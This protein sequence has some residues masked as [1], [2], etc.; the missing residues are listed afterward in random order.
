MIPARA[1]AKISCR[2]VAA[3]RSQ[4]VMENLKKFFIDRTPPGCRFSFKTFGCSDAVRVPTDSPWLAAARAG[5]KD[6][7]G[8]EAALIGTGGSIP[9]VG[10]IRR[11]LGIDSLLVGFGLDDDRVHSPNE[12][13]ELACFRRGIL[14]Q[15]AMLGHLAAVVR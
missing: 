6:A 13:F 4:K 14:A 8:R 11:V 10:E 3:Q 9:V 5:L 7:F 2:L 1:A 15:A 12:K